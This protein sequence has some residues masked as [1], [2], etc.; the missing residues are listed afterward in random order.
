MLLSLQFYVEAGYWQYD[1]G[2]TRRWHGFL[3]SSIG[4]PQSDFSPYSFDSYSGACELSVCIC[5]RSWTRSISMRWCFRLDPPPFTRFC[6]LIRVSGSTTC[7]LKALLKN[8]FVSHR[9]S[10]AHS[11]HQTLYSTTVLV[12]HAAPIMV[13]AG[14]NTGSRPLTH[15]RVLNTMLTENRPNSSIMR[16][17]RIGIL[18]HSIPWTQCQVPM[19]HHFFGG[20]Y[21]RFGVWTR[22]RSILMHQS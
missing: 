6:V 14:T 4:I 3:F 11:T 8:Y 22:S 9:F 12:V 17:T 1:S 2:V 7:H 16:P 10:I 15:W 18:C 5:S 21:I 20:G 13:P 19:S